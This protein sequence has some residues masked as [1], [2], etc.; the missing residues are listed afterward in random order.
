VL[1]DALRREDGP[2]P[3]DRGHRAVTVML[4]IILYLLIIFFPLG[5]ISRWRWRW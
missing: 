3:K 5:K 2:R 4:K 1:R